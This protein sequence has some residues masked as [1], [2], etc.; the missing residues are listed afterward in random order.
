MEKTHQTKNKNSKNE[1]ILYKARHYL[2]KR[3]LLCLHYSFI[4]SYLNYETTELCSTN[5]TYQK[6]FRSQQRHTIRIIF[7]QNK[8][9]HRR[10]PLKENEILNIYQLNIFND[11]LF[12][13]RVEVMKFYS[14]QS[15]Q[16]DNI[17]NIKIRSNFSRN[18]FFSS[19]ITEWD[20]LHRHIPNTDSLNVFKLSLLKFVR[21]V[22]NSVFEINNP[23]GLKFIFR[24]QLFALS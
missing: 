4:Q 6:K 18:S 19:A 8:F 22:G 21:P 23:Y 3:V 20:K 15:S 7:H 10:E 13:Y 9:A 1:D 12:L 11:F 17:S 16:I 24:F 5:R 14:T 2:D